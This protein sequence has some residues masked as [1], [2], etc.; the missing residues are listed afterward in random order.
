VRAGDTVYIPD[1]GQS[2][3]SR[4]T[5]ILG[6]VLPAAAILAVMHAL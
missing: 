2:D 1:A 5:K 3:W 4:L 6:E